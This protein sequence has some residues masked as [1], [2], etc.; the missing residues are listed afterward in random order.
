MDRCYRSV[1]FAAVAWLALVG[2]APDV[3]SKDVK[4]EAKGK[5]EARLNSVPS[6]QAQ[7][8]GQAASA[9]DGQNTNHADRHAASELQA[10]WVAT[11]AAVDAARWTKYS[12]IASCFGSTLVMIALF[13]AYRA[14]G[15]AR[16]ASRR[17]LRAYVGN[18]SI[19]FVHPPGTNNEIRVLA[20]YGNEGATPALNVKRHLL[21][22]VM[23]DG[24]RFANPEPHAPIRTQ[25][26]V[27]LLFRGDAR[28]T[29]AHCQC[30]PK[31]MQ[32]ID[33]GGAIVFIWGWIE[34]DDVFGATH[35]TSFRYFYDTESR[36][37]GHRILVAPEGNRFS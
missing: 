9:T 15:I 1:V 21:V 31:I 28:T 11:Q 16:E 14:N 36:K 23:V 8:A 24:D 10:Q 26:S 30:P 2:Q 19:E 33:Q 13:F 12:V 29:E 34:Y 32:A 5:V 6:G 17:E 27:G 18:S 3:I 22:G 37:L 25:Q 20:T 7:L 35:K 4:A